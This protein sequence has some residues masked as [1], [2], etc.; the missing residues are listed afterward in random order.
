MNWNY[1]KELIYKASLF[2]SL[3]FIT[4]MFY[5]STAAVAADITKPEGFELIKKDCLPL[6]QGSTEKNTKFIFEHNTKNI[7]DGVVSIDEIEDQGDENVIH[8]THTPSGNKII[9]VINDKGICNYFFVK[10]HQS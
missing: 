4:M 9:A 3:I 8:I 5:M 7:Q 6:G 1:I 10:G 2:V